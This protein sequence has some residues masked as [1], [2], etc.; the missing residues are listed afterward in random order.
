MWDPDR[1]LAF[2]DQ[3]ARPFR[4]LVAQVD[5]TDVRE[6]A[7]L[8]CGPGN[9]TVGLALRWPDA[10]VVG[11]DSS[12]EMIAATQAADRVEFVQADLRDWEPARPVDVLLSNATLQ[13]VPGHLELLPRLAGHVADGGWLAFQVPGNFGEPAHVLLRELTGTDRWRDLLHHLHRP[14]VHEPAAYLDALLDLGLEAQVWETTYHQLLQGEDAVLEWMSGTALRPIFA[15]L[16]AA[17]GREL[18]LADYRELLRTAYSP[19]RHGTVL[20]YRRVFAVARKP[21][22]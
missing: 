9:L 10:H 6:V 5:A 14:G 8:G 2:A 20:P 4:D 21:G 16:D 17:G 7:D 11:V 19:G 12:A 15:A 1:Y 22:R 13:W 18:F 3:R